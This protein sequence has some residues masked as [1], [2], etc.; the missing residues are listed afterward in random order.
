MLQLF[1]QDPTHV[2]I[3]AGKHNHVASC[4]AIGWTLGQSFENVEEEKQM[5]ESIIERYV[6]SH[7][8]GMLCVIYGMFGD[9][10]TCK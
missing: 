6:L 1:R 10:A 5:H 4:H 9:Q 2:Y 8:V 7:K 3:I